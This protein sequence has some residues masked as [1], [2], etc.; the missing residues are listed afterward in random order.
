MVSFQQGENAPFL[1]LMI[2]KK[3]WTLKYQKKTPTN[4]TTNQQPILLNSTISRP[5]SHLEALSHDF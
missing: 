2:W 4:Q 1:L 3:T 5:V